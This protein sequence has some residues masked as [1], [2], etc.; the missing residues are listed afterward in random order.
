MP[1]VQKFRLLNAYSNIH[2]FIFIH[3]VLEPLQI[4]MR[5]CDNTML[6]KE[7]RIIFY[8]WGSSLYLLLLCNSKCLQMF[9]T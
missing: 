3:Y 7:L 4:L 8:N 1:R 6:M 2:I 9:S 5:H